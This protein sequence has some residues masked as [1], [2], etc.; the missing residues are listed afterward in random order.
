MRLVDNLAAH[1]AQTPSLQSVWL[2]SPGESPIAYIKN[3]K[4]ASS[5]VVV[6][7]SN[8]GVLE[9]AIRTSLF[10]FQTTCLIIA[11]IKHGS[12][13]AGLVTFN[14]TKTLR[15]LL[16]SVIVRVN[17]HI[18]VCSFR[19]RRRLRSQRGLRYLLRLIRDQVGG[20]HFCPSVAYKFHGSLK[21]RLV[22]I[23]AFPWNIGNVNLNL[24]FAAA[25]GPGS[26]FRMLPR[27]LE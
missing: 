22:S 3:F 12:V 1:E 26:D 9:S 4:S 27:S 16:L 13:E 5:S 7:I 20:L 15:A 6:G 8:C 18:D 11:F 24:R 23:K 17:V 2:T 14:T 25:P 19:Q 10:N 21:S